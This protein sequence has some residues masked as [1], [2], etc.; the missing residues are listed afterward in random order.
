MT[1]VRTIALSAARTS[2]PVTKKRLTMDTKEVKAGRAS[3]AE[4]DI[5]KR[6]FTW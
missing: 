3:T 1:K 6:L 4:I 2:Q 5:S